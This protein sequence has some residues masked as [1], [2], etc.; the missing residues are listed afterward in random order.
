M[1]P[2]GHSE[3]VG[4]PYLD[5]HA[6][7]AAL[8]AGDCPGE[9]P[10]G[11]IHADVHSGRTTVPAAQIHVIDRARFKPFV[12]GLADGGGGAT[13]SG[14]TTIRVAATTLRVRAPQASID[15]LL[16]TDSIRRALERGDS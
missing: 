7:A 16:G 12:T 3:W 5:P 2:R 6:Y 10:P 14:P 9:L 8:D 1:A 15:I 13:A 11:A 4:E